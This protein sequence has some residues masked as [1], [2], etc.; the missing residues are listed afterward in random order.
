MQKKKFVKKKV[1]VEK[2]DLA[3]SGSG[4]QEKNLEKETSCSDCLQNMHNVYACRLYT[5]YL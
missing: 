1:N 5:W 2:K 4:K 3:L